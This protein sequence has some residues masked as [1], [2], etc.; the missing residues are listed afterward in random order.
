[1]AVAAAVLFVVIILEKQRTRHRSTV[2][3][4]RPAKDARTAWPT[5]PQPGGKTGNVL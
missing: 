2:R 5:L 4:R 1:M 3:P